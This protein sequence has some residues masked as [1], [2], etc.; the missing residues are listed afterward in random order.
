MVDKPAV[1]I[2][3]ELPGRLRL[4]L[5]HPP[6]ELDR[7]EA[8]VGTH[9][10]IRSVAYSPVTR[11]VL[12]QFDPQE[13]T[14]EEIVVRVGLSLALDYGPAPVRILAQPEVRE[15][16]D[17]AFYSGLL[18]GTALVARLLPGEEKT[19]LLLDWG[20]SLGTIGAVLQHG[21]I[22]VNRRGNFDPEVLSAVYLITALI[23]GNFLPAALFTWATT[24]GRHLLQGPAPGV[25]LRPVQAAR[26][27]TEAPFYEVVVAP[28]HPEPD[29]M[30]LFRLLPT[31]L[32]RALGGT[33]PGNLIEEI[34]QVAQLHGEVLEGLGELRRGIPL[35]IR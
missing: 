18:L 35:R 7:M 27:D 28:D 24:F 12:V 4:R 25:E 23:R 22:E 15:M 1:T 33:G 13:V 29:R 26:P 16:S 2:V 20:A 3:H 30:N 10:G 32:M 31:T 34:R 8:S 11:S 14:R 19:R 21:L 5:S 17:S 6:R 9:A